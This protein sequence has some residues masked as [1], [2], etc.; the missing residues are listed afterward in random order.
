[1]RITIL[2]LEQMRTAMAIRLAKA[3]HEVTLYSRTRKGAAGL[4][5]TDVRVAFTV[6]A[7]VN[8]AQVA[9]TI[10]PND[11]A[12]DALTFYPGGLLNNLP[13]SAIHLCMSTISV[14]VSRRLAAAHAEASQG[15]VAAPILGLTGA[16]ASG[17]LRI[18]AAGPEIDVIRC[19]GILEALSQGVT[20]VGP[21]AELAHA[22]KLGASAFTVALVEA[23]AETLAFG[24]KAGIAPSHYLAILNQSLF[25]SPLLDVLGGLMVR[26]D[27]EPAVQTVASAAGDLTMLVQA[28]R[29]LNVAMPLAQPLLQ[30]LQDAKSQGLAER[31]LTVLSQIRSQDQGK[32][33][34]AA[35]APDADRRRPDRRK[36]AEPRKDRGP[37]KRKA[38]WA[39]RPAHAERR[40]PALPAE[41]EPE[42]A[43]PAPAAEPLPPTAGTL[44]LARADDG[45]V[46]L[47]AWKTTHFE[48]QGETVWAWVDGARHA[49][50]WN[51]LAEVQDA[52]DT[53]LFVQIQPRILVNPNAVKEIKPL[54]WGRARVLLAGGT[55]F[56]AGRKARRT[57]TFLLN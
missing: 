22:L 57:L 54:F 14:E 50:F 52:V 40:K 23:L 45:T 28:A 18:L 56:T 33:P 27:H 10:F 6:A 13:S 15:Y 30:Q 31:D 37:E 46:E 19:L 24:E 34:A 12:E 35:G 8:Q 16:T 55:V 32:A 44:Y 53:I 47:D 25:K 51:N 48:C 20:R 26:H 4:A 39:G 7:A 29:E 17:N 5:D 38:A 9:I 41:P 43:A 3:G 11:A 2:G 21:R 36:V 42:P 49:T 1:M